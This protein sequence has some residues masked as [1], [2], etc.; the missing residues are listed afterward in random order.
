MIKFEKN[1]LF[2]HFFREA[3]ST[4]IPEAYFTTSYNFLYSKKK[5]NKIF[6]KQIF[7]KMFAAGQKFQSFQKN[8][9]SVFKESNLLHQKP[10][11]PRKY[12]TQC[13]DIQY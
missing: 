7:V 3:H 4:N 9:Q 13:K 1:F 10:L 11:I 6:K 2:R 12:I 8:F 5:K